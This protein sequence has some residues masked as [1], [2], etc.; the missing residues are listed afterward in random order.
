MYEY[1]LLS[2]YNRSNLL[3]NN[4]NN[5]NAL[6]GEICVEREVALLS[7]MQILSVVFIGF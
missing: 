7:V 4:F 5:A 6:V 3:L 2:I 1:E